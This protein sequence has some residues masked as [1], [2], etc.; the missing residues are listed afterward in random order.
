V[1]VD[2]EVS[3]EARKFELMAKCVPMHPFREQWIREGNIF[4]KEV[5]A[6]TK[7]LPELTK[8]L[9]DGMELGIPT[10]Y[11]GDDEVFEQGCQIVLVQNTKMGENIPICH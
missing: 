4:K 5:L 10:C 2:A 3:G 1:S 9:K 6:Y 7:V 8:L 11:Y